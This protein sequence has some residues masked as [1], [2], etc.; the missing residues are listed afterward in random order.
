MRKNGDDGEWM[1]SRRNKL[2]LRE[3]FGPKAC[4]QKRESSEGNPKRRG[5]LKYK[6]ST[7]PKTNEKGA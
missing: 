3:T 6:R 5:S 7:D 1:T 2:A 4:G